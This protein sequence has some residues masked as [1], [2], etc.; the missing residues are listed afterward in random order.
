NGQCPNPD[1]HGRLIACAFRSAPAGGSRLGF[2]TTGHRSSNPD[3]SS[4]RCAISRYPLRRCSAQAAIT[5]LPN[6][7]PD[8]SDGVRRLYLPCGTTEVAETPT[9]GPISLTH[10]RSE[11]FVRP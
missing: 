11:P 7:Q 1:F 4:F 10:K 6:A 8:T 9:H 3:I 2:T 5:E